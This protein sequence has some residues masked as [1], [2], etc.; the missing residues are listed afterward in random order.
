MRVER[1][2]LREYSVLHRYLDD[3]SA[4]SI[5]ADATA[6]VEELMQQRPGLGA[7]KKAQG[8]DWHSSRS[9]IGHVAALNL[10]V[11]S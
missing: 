9:G 2:Q 4:C 3:R 6:V 7:G 11:G 8:H 5:G 10:S 1:H